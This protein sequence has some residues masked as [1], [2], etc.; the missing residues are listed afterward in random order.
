MKPEMNES[1][2]Y[3]AHRLV[4]ENLSVLEMAPIVVAEV[5]KRVFAKIDERIRTWVEKQDQWEGIFTGFLEDETSFKPESWPV[6]ERGNYCAYYTIGCNKRDGEDFEYWLSSLVG[7]VDYQL[8]ILF[9]VNAS[10]V[11]RLSGKGTRPGQAW[12]NF[13]AKEY[14]ERPKLKELG[15]QLSGESLFYPLYIDAAAL[16]SAYPNS[17]EDV[18]WPL[19][20]GLDRLA[21]AHH[22][23]DQ[24]LAIALTWPF[25][26]G[27]VS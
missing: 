8:G 19:D 26:K 17:L 24:L 1:S 11:T 27:S 14:G 2:E 22:E 25:T 10:D 16:A 12:K 4:I 13:L 15:F 3:Q 7:A 18:L 9:S 21:K 20:E 6:D 23:I 5:E